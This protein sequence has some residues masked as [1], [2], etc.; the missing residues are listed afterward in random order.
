[1]WVI[2]TEGYFGFKTRYV[3]RPTTNKMRSNTRNAIIVQQQHRLHGFL[4]T[5]S[6][7]LNSSMLKEPCLDLLYGAR[8]LS[9]VNF[10]WT[11]PYLLC[12]SAFIMSQSLL[13]LPHSRLPTSLN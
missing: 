3:V 5:G 6:S 2:S 9:L 4:F 13:T 11:A 8:S 12:R 10:I 1:M 7:T